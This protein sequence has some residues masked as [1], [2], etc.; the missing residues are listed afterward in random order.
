VRITLLC[1]YWVA[2]SDDIEAYWRKHKDVPRFVR[3]D[4]VR[5]FSVLER[6]M[7]VLLFALTLLLSTLGHWAARGFPEAVW[8]ALG[9]TFTNPW[10][11]LA[12]ADPPG[13]ARV[14]WFVMLAVFLLACLLAL[15]ALVVPR[16]ARAKEAP[17]TPLYVVFALLVPGSGL[18]DEDTA[19]VGLLLLLA[20][21]VVGLSVLRDLYALPFQFD[22]GIWGGVVALAAVYLLNAFALLGVFVWSRRKQ[23][24]LER[25]VA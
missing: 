13:V 14:V 11:S 19:G 9:H 15:I 6:L 4:I 3:L 10:T 17:R 24:Q 18:L 2:Q 22:L 12:T 16:S 21:A 1:K 8:S 25:T 5:Y 7:L 23:Q 20:W